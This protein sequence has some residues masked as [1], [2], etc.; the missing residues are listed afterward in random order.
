LL[1]RFQEYRRTTGNGVSRIDLGKTVRKVVDGLVKD[2]AE[3]LPITVTENNGR[4]ASSPLGGVNLLV[5]R[6]SHDAW[7]HGRAPDVRRLVRYL[8]SNSVR[9]AAQSGGQVVVAVEPGEGGARL[10]VEDSAPFRP[11]IEVA[12][13][14]DPSSPPREGTDSLELAACR[15]LARRLR[16]G[17][18]AENRREGGLRLTAEFRPANQA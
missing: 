4:W 17:L 5:K 9:A 18:Q 8:V 14:F 7:I 10:C 3:T 13:L 12:T 1:N 15:S 16:C 6:A 2:L 11:P